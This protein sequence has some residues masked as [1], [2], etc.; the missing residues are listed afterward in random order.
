LIISLA[1]ALSTLFSTASTAKLFAIS[2]LICYSVYCLLLHIIYR[3]TILC[4]K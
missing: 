3:R 2:I 1:I 4:K